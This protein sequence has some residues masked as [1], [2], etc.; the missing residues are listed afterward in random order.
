VRIKASNPVDRG[1]ATLV[2]S[3]RGPSN[4]LAVPNPQVHVVCILTTRYC[5][6]I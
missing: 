2:W 4:A 6:L 5:R 1:N 3:G